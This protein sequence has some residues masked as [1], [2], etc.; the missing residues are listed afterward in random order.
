MGGP[1]RKK[2]VKMVLIYLLGGFIFGLGRA[3][4]RAA[5]GETI[6]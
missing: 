2:N 5:K 6:F 3:A 1:I 4:R